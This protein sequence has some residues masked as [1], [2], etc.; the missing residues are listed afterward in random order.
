[1]R[2][3][4]P[5]TGLIAALCIMHAACVGGRPIHYYSLNPPA[6][7]TGNSRP[8]GLAL[9]IGRIAT[10][11]ALQ[12]GRIRYRSG[13]N[14]VG[15]YE[16]HR[17]TERPATMVQDLLL[18]TLRASGKYRVVQEASTA[19]AGDY[20]VRGKLYELEEIDNPGIRT[21]V[22]LRLELLD[23]KTGMVV[24]NRYYDRDEPVE[25]KT[26]PDLVLSLE[27]NLQQL[28]ADAASGID[29]FLSNRS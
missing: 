26:I 28:I 16:Y 4:H 23:R 8:D 3:S 13:S 11:E 6:A 1:M 22:S 14:E 25:G 19:A 2:F 18:R 29:V 21:R 17:W 9:L 27:H 12:D 15:A 10:P 20:L 5:L 7:A 24:W